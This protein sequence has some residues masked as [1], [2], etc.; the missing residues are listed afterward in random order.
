MTE[1]EETACCCG[2]HREAHKRLATFLNGPEEKFIFQAM[3]IESGKV[4][5]FYLPPELGQLERRIRL[6]KYDLD[7]AAACRAVKHNLDK[8]EAREQVETF[9]ASALRTQIEK[10]RELPDLVRETIQKAMTDLDL[11]IRAPIFQALELDVV[12]RDSWGDFP[13]ETRMKK[14]VVVRQVKMPRH[15]PKGSDSFDPAAF[16]SALDASIRKLARQK[17]VIPTQS[18]VSRDIKGFSGD[19]ESLH[20]K[21]KACKTGKRWSAYAK[22]VLSKAGIQLKPKKSRVLNCPNL[23]RLFSWI[24]S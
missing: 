18:Q 14:G 13:I 20:K 17:R 5:I 2:L 11:A 24:A 7:Q 21:F 12:R 16:L 1:A 4:L 3:G 8:A 23:I 10:L 6:N 22:G 15:R 19:G 9:Y